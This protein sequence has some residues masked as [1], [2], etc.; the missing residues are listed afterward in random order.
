[1]IGAAV[2]TTEFA[3]HPG[4]AWGRER[5]EGAVWEGGC[6]HLCR[7]GVP[8]LVPPRRLA[9]GRIGGVGAVLRPVPRPGLAVRAG[10]TPVMCGAERVGYGVEGPA[11][12]PRAWRERCVGHMTAISLPTELG[13]V[14]FAFPIPRGAGGTTWSQPGCVWEGRARKGRPAGRKRGEGALWGRDCRPSRVLAQGCRSR[15]FGP[16]QL[17]FPVPG[18]TGGKGGAHPSIC[19]AE[20]G[21]CGVEWVGRRAASAAGALCRA[22]G[23]GTAVAVPSEREFWDFCVPTALHL[24]RPR[25]L[26]ARAG[27]AGA[28]AGQGG[29]GMVYAGRPAGA[30]ERGRGSPHSVPGPRL[31]D[32]ELG[33][34]APCIPRPQRGA[35]GEG[36]RGR[37]C[38][39]QR[40][41]ARV[42]KGGP[43]GRGRR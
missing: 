1:M 40:G 25:G 33:P 14:R 6:R 38:A 30:E 39:G 37:G 42:W 3:A 26:A 4:R 13:R 16:R 29:D 41:G 2:I 8:S 15:D 23:Q 31:T 7:P 22:A 34:S 35:G 24:R 28:C 20:R 5:G 21:V 27:R 19:R 36:G 11:A 32:R 10:R 17:A 18:G 12:G 43:A 9:H